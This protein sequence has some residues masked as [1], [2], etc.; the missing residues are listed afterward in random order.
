MYFSWSTLALQ[1]VNFAVLVWLLRR[2]L[3]QPVLRMV[4]A[5]R[6]EVDKQYADAHAVEAKAQE[7]L[8]AIA[9]E[10]AGIAAERVAALK[11][12]AAQAEEAA[13]ARRTEAQ[14]DATALLEGARK[15]LAAERDQALAEARRAALDLGSEIAGRLL[16]ELPMALRAEAWI[17]RIG[18]HLA[19]LARPDLDALTR[20]LADGAALTVVTASALPTAAAEAWR[21]RL[22]R[23]LGDGIAITFGVD[24]QLIAGAELHFPT[25]V[26]RFSWQSALAS[27]R[28]KIEADGDA[29]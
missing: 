12:A 21:S 1:T 4:D 6:A 10:R 29:R 16:A 18:Q 15:T 28:A 8:A 14:R 3:Y 13:A 11:T 5:R 7:H 20:Q 22:Q 19:A 25:A 17:D 2:F 26:L 24:P 23:I 9:A 27:L